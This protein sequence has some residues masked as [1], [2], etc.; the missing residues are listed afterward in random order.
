[1]NYLYAFPTLL[2][3]K[4]HKQQIDLESELWLLVSVKELRKT[5][6]IKQNKRS[7]CITLVISF[8]LLIS[9]E[10]ISFESS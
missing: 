3:H 8:C 2:T 1:M 10:F 7:L 5:K 4:L 9:F 6:K